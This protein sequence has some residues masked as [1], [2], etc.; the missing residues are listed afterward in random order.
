MA[1][2]MVLSRTT[3]WTCSVTIFFGLSGWSYSA[4]AAEATSPTNATKTNKAFKGRLPPHYAK[5]VTEEQRA[6]IYA[7]QGE[8]RARID[9]AREQLNTL[10]KEE[11]EKISA[12]LTEDQKKKVEE[13]RSSANTKKAVEKTELQKTEVKKTDNTQTLKNPVEQQSDK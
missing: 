12:V 1:M 8:Y 2:R 6:K 10:L 11:K 3:L 9:A 5:V 7:I 13:F 4:L